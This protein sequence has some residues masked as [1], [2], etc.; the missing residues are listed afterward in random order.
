MDFDHEEE[1]ASNKDDQIAFVAML[2]D[3]PFL[4]E[5][6]QVPAAK[7][8]KIQAT[9]GFIDKWKSLNGEVLT[10]VTLMKKINNMKSRIKKKTDANQT[11]NAPI[12]LKNWEK[13]F[14]KLVKSDENPSYSKIPV[15]F[16]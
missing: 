4:L 6:S 13:D 11:G 14:L 5:K 16:I 3:F 7:A 15:S 12:V 9:T 1:E 8:L 10:K 2:K